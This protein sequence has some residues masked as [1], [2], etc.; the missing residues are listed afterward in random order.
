MESRQQTLTEIVNKRKQSQPKSG[1]TLEQCINGGFNNLEQENFDDAI[2]FLLKA[3]K[4]DVYQ[5]Y[6]LSRLLGEAY[7]KRYEVNQN[8]DDLFLALEE[9]HLAYDRESNEEVKKNIANHL[10][11]AIF[12]AASD[13]ENK[14]DFIAAEKSYGICLKYATMEEII[15]EVKNRITTIENSYFDYGRQHILNYDSSEKRK[16]L[17][18]AILY[19]ERALLKSEQGIIPEG[20][21]QD[22]I[23]NNL[24]NAYY[25]LGCYFKEKQKYVE[26]R[27]CFE[28]CLSY[29]KIEKMKEA[30]EEQI[31]SIDNQSSSYESESSSPRLSFS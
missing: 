30:A 16:D 29:V 8:K 23:S 2:Y 26:A 1:H 24:A 25:H 7:L 22:L 12:M 20:V 9:L 27:G 4:L 3:K 15:F 6:N 31:A 13:Q 17:E 19:F 28:S 5:E 14:G 11:N 18:H 10:A 21:D